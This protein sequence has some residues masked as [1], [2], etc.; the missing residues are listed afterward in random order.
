MNPTVLVIGSTLAGLTTAL[1]LGRHG[2]AVTIIEQP[3]QHAAST[4]HESNEDAFPFVLMGCHTATLSLLETLGTA[5]RVQWDDRI[6]FEL[7]GSNGHL[8]R[9]RRPPLPAPLH[10]LAG[11]AMFAGMPA[12]DR[13]RFLMWAERTWEQDPALPVD[14]ESHTAEVW[15]RGIGQSE[16][17]RAQVWTPL[18]RFL[19]GDDVGTVS[20][21]ALLSALM[22][23]FF[24]SR[25]H[26]RL[27][28]PSLS[29]DQL[30]YQPL[31]EALTGMGV[32]IKT[33][34]ADRL[35]FSLHGVTG[36]QLK[37]GHTLTTD[38]YIVALSRQAMTPLL[39]E[40]LLARYAY[41]QH[42]DALVDTPAVT[43]YRWIDQP[44][45]SSRL[46]LLADRT[47]HWMCLK[48]A[49]DPRHS[50]ISFIVT[51]L[52]EWLDG[53]D[54]DLLNLAGKDLQSAL[55]AFSNARELSHRIVRERKA[56]LSMRPGT[57]AHRPLQRSPFPNLLLA[58]EWTDTGLPSTVESAIVSGNRCAQALIDHVG[59]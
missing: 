6:G 8:V 1:R 46:V 28:V 24:S 58:G 41:F 47:F 49:A 59:P 9:L 21:A 25:R 2:Y 55:P 31:R 50:V 34:N 23:C 37:E 52:S 13:W 43:V 18:C 22:R 53:A 57:A 33:G 38:W 30:L 12:R 56:V 40:R 19:L 16:C 5:D 26:S 20:A 42:I 29:I 17:A 27:A 11:L 15:L 44:I 45:H 54:K 7:L 35:D 32:S 48:P 14:L 4:Q 3:E 36:L 51:G 10:A 39:P